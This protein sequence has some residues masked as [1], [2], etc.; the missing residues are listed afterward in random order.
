MAEQRGG[1]GNFAEDREKASE[2]GRK[3]GQHSGGNFKNVS[4]RAS[5]AGKK[6]GQSSHGGG[7]KSDNS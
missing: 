4:Q 3:G 1:S 7:R 6:G 2:A 5:E